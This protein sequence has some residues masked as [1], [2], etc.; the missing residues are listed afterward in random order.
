[1]MAKKASCDLLSDEDLMRLLIEGTAD[2]VGED[3]FHALV[4]NLARSLGVFSAFISE[5]LVEEERARARAFW[6]EEGWVTDYAFNIAGTPCEHVLKQGRQF[7]FSEDLV[8]SFPEANDIPTFKLVSYMGAPII[9]TDGTVMGH[10]A[11]L[12]RKP[13]P[14]SSLRHESLFRLFAARAAAEYRRLR[15][16]TDLRD[17]EQKLSRLVDGAMD[18]ILEL[19]SDLKVIQFNRA[20][21]QIFG[22]PAKHTIGFGF[23]GLLQ[24][25]GARVFTRLVKDLGNGSHDST[26]SAWMA[27]GL[28]AMRGDGSAF[29][30]EATVSRLDGPQATHYTVVLRNVEDRIRAAE[31]IRL[32]ASETH[33]LRQEINNLRGVSQEMSGNCPALQKVLQ[34]IHHVAETDATVLITGETGTGKEV[35]ARTLHAASQ[36]KE[37]PL[38]CVNCA[39][40]PANLIESEFFGHERGAFTGATERREGRFALA[41]G[42]TFFLDEVGELPL[43]LQGKLL[44]VLQEGEF[45]PVGSSKTRKV[46]VRLIAATNRELAKEVEAGKFREDLFYRLN[47][48]PIHLPPLRDRGKDI[49]LLADGFAHRF[50]AVMGRVYQGLSPECE[51]RLLAHSWPGNIRELRNVIERSLITSVNGRLDLSTALPF[52]VQ[53][54]QSLEETPHNANAASPRIL[55][56]SEWRDLERQNIRRALDAC[57][58]KISGKDG[59]ASRLGLRP[60]TLS[61]RMKALK[62]E[63]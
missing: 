61:S 38:V 16:E 1:M 23:T 47:V 28:Q 33:Q 35:A 9:H 18:A 21:E 24:P 34:S 14:K 29:T 51:E 52:S 40:I 26:R 63:R 41:D 5:Y 19:D 15:T 57:D 56:E 45:E 3:F 8:G 49:L 42:G 53:A 10:L 46:D 22:C 17:R 27:G 50:A 55:T 32:L 2:K 11:I 60:S 12:D 62:I 43:D 6:T 20:A 44:R 37:K 39:A 58:W 36:R 7:Q 13:L 54:L 25:E 30:A 31:R 59:A 4:E 48:F